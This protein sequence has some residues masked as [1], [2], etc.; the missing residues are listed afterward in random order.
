MDAHRGILQ[1]FH[2]PWHLTSKRLHSCSACQKSVVPHHTDPRYSL[3]HRTITLE[4]KASDSSAVFLRPGG[5]P[6]SRPTG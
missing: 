1:C 5:F 4:L 6:Y 3:P 2:P